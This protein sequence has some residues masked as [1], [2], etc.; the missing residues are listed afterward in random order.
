M[1]SAVCCMCSRYDIKNIK[2]CFYFFFF[3]VDSLSREGVR[4]IWF[5]SVIFFGTVQYPFSSFFFFYTFMFFFFLYI[6]LFVFLFTLMIFVNRINTLLNTLLY[7]PFPVFYS[8]F[9]FMVN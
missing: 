8:V 6:S 9:C 2:H 5:V 1:P 3:F 7:L 4:K